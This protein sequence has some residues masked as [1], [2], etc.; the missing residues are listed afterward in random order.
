LLNTLS[1]P[2]GSILPSRLPLIQRSA[3]EIILHKRLAQI[4]VA[5]FMAS[6]RAL[7]ERLPNK[8]YVINLHRNR[9][10]Y[11]LT[12]CA[13]VM[14]GQCTL[15]PPNRQ[16]NTLA[17]L[18]SA[19]PGCYR[20]GENDDGPL[21]LQQSRPAE[22]SS[23]IPNIPVQQLCAIAFTSGST[24]SPSPNLKTWHTLHAGT[25]ANCDAMLY[26]WPNPI[27][28]SA[29]VLA[30]VPAQHNWG[31]ETSIMMPLFANLSIS[32]A[33]P[34][35]PQDIVAALDQLPAPRI[36][37]SSPLHLQTLLRSKLRLPQLER[38]FTATA[39][40]SQPLAQELEV[41]FGAPVLDVF[42]S[43][44][45]G[46][47]AVRQTA[48]ED[49]WRISA[50]FHL[51]MVRQKLQV[52]AAHLP[53]TVTLADQLE[54]VGTHQFRWLARDND[55][56]NVAGKRASLADLNQR[57]L[58]IKGV[59]DGMIFKPVESP[60]RLA[61]V[62]VA[63]ELT[64]ADIRK[65]MAQ[66]L[67]PVFMPRPVVFVSAMPRNETGKLPASAVQAVFTASRQAKK[68]KPS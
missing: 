57:L 7:S 8:P 30:T 60:E 34:L 58:A 5:E 23:E 66:E 56:V 39:P 67:D 42:G 38:V 9:H 29:N 24:G 37:V 33:S 13:S 47:F 12:F 61:A 59:Q 48:R 54:L 64:A 44:E 6:A 26:G 32:A 53:A 19:Y 43:S 20:M 16:E 17:N 27:S 35:Y 1:N 36:L 49:L 41:A 10:D 62:I 3:D 52:S 31:L 2:P 51:E 11:L 50:P 65:A 40:L 25:Q 68:P 55:Q 15:M 22:Y 4:S 14:A 18:E 46:I 63:P 45:T 21:G 28:G